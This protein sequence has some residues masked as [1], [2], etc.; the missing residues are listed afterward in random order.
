MLETIGTIMFW[1]AGVFAA[2]VIIGFALIGYF[3]LK[4]M[5]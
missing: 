2:L 1:A 5:K 3:C 4:G